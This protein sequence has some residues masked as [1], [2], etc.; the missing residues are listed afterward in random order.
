MNDNNNKLEICY[1]K[2]IHVFGGL[3]ADSCMI[4]YEFLQLCS[5]N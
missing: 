4:Q 3:I 1:T 2:N 5:K